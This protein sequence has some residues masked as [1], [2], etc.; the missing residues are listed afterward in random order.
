MEAFTNISTQIKTLKANHRNVF[1]HNDVIKAKEK[2]TQE[3]HIESLEKALEE[4]KAMLKG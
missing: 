2:K 4:I 1:E 3:E